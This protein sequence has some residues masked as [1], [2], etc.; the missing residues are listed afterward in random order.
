MMAS[1]LDL[2]SIFGDQAIRMLRSK[3]PNASMLAEELFTIFSGTNPINIPAGSTLQPSANPATPLLTAP[4]YTQGQTIIDFP[5][6]GTISVQ[7]DQLIFTNPDGQTSGGGASVGGTA[8]PT[9]FPGLV[10]SGSG[11]DYLV[12]IYPNGI[13]NAAVEVTVTQLQIDPS[14]TIPPGTAAL[15]TKTT[16]GSY[17]M[18][19]PVWLTPP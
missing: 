11:S 16:D 14:Q 6:V 3:W 18:Q 10:V 2:V 15:V 8:A 9:C 1:P 4:G 7:G 17:Y 5:H 12:N 19:V 13:G